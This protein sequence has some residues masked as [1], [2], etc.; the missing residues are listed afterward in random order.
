MI[1][2]REAKKRGR[3]SLKRHYFLYVAVCLM[4]AFI[5]AEFSSSLDAARSY[6][7]FKEEDD[8]GSQ[9][10]SLGSLSIVYEDLAQEWAEENPDKLPEKEEIQEEEQDH[11]VL[12]RRRGVFAKIVNGITSGSFL[13]TVASVVRNLSGSENLALLAP[14]LLSAG[15]SF[16]LWF[17]FSNMFTAVSRRI[18]LEGRVYDEVPI[19]RF[20]YFL[21]VKKWVRVSWVMFVTAMYRLFWCLTIAGAVIKRY[22]YYLVPYIMAENPTLSA[23]EAITLSRR[24][25]KGHK[26]QCFVFELSYVGWFILAPSPWGSRRSSTQIPQG[27]RP[28]PSITPNTGGW[29]WKGESPAPRP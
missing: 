26:W 24:M 19:Q 22:S 20:V 15:L 9:F 5:G 12:G 21:R 1:S 16:L 18:F 23:R 2:R 8:L 28:F 13:V 17:F 11:P 4:A 27:R 7:S 3:K 29:P 14:I 25:M 10:L 6:T